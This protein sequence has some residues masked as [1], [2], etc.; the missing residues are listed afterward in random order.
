MPFWS[1][2]CCVSCMFYV[3]ELRD[4][5]GVPFYVGKGSK[6]R[7]HEH[8]K[9]ARRGIDSHLCSKI[10]KL[11]RLGF[12]V[13]K[14]VVFRSR[15]E[16]AAFS[17]E[18]RLIAYYGRASLTNQTDGGDGPA[19]MALHARERIA[20]S[21]R[22]KVASEATRNRQRLAKLG[23]HRTAKTKRK[24]AAT[25]RTIKKPWAVNSRPNLGS[26]F[27][28]HR[29]TPEHRA[30]FL[31]KRIGH[32]VTQETRNKISKAKLGSIPWNKKTK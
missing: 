28:G 19:G 5:F 4:Q 14:A 30:K 1:F 27:A 2:R 31:A 12:P 23:T 9:R 22:G 18:I 21:R 26:G 25:Q 8:E 6:R 13:Q 24:I 7:M 17:E 20:A 29:W 32:T 10:R 11:W 3:Y 16:R 15:D